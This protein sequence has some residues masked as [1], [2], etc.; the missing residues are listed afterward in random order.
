MLYFVCL[1]T[2][3]MKTEGSGTNGKKHYQNEERI[4]KKEN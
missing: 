4:R 1:L 2:A 3:D